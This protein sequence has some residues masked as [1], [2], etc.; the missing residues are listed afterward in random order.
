MGQALLWVGEGKAAQ[1][2]PWIL[3]SFL[4]H[5]YF[6]IIDGCWMPKLCDHFPS[7]VIK[8][9]HLPVIASNR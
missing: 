1:G 8:N 2:Q 4:I 6:G 7:H 3:L 9:A 5:N